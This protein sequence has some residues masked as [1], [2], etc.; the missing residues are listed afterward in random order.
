MEPETSG[1][2][3][4]P[5]AT[6][7]HQMP[8]VAATYRAHPSMMHLLLA[9]KQTTKKDTW[10]SFRAIPKPPAL[11]LNDANIERVKKLLGTW[12]QVLSQG[13]QESTSFQLLLVS[14][15]T[16][17]RSGPC[18]SMHPQYGVD[19]LSISLRSCESLQ[20]RSQLGSLDFL[21]T[22]YQL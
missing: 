14:P 6:Q 8:S 11:H 15:P 18:S 10:V 7:F 3:G 21:R 22:T 4:E 5:P 13:M 16:Q 2:P 9:L 12:L 19:F 20:K 1:R 17:P